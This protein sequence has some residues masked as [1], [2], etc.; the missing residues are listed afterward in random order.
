MIK[1]ITI[2]IASLG[3]ALSATA[4]QSTAS[5][6]NEPQPSQ[7]SQTI[8]TLKGGQSFNFTDL[9]A[10]GKSRNDM[11]PLL[12][13]QTGLMAVAEELAMTR[14]LV[15]EGERL[16]VLNKSSDGQPQS[17]LDNVYALAVYR[18]IAGVCKAPDSDKETRRFFD[19]NPQAYA[20]PAQ[21]QLERIIMP[22]NAMIDNF[23]TEA[24]LAL[25][26]QAVS[27]GYAR[28]E[29]LLARAQKAFPDLGQGDLGWMLLQGQQPL[30]KA[31]MAAEPGEVLG[32]L[33]DGDYWYLIKVQ[34]KRN[35]RNP[36]WEEVRVQAPR[37]ALEYC[38]ET[39]RERV[40]TDLFQ[41]YEVKINKS[42]IREQAKTFSIY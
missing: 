28:F 41:R 22:A 39:Q 17:P 19:E 14:A 15:V 12:K 8:V 3:L 38:R 33:R 21:V 40:L 13:S 27:G 18:K 7:T 16:N 32:P 23:T 24:W 5:A 11:L 4:Q 29:A 20:I 36:S 1:R 42:A 30:I 37:R 26:M 34:A 9:L 31:L 25:Q 2:L 10:F 35:T 6:A